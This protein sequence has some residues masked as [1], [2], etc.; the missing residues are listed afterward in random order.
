MNDIKQ[1]NNIF[2]KSQT[3]ITN[4]IKLILIFISLILV[5][6]ISFQIYLYYSQE[7]IKKTLNEEVINIK[8]TNNHWEIFGNKRKFKAR[9]IIVTF[10]F[11]QTKKLVKKYL[12]GSFLK[13]KVKMT[14]NLTV[15]LSQKTKQSVPISSIKLNNSLVSWISNENSKKR[16]TKK[17]CVETKKIN[18]NSKESSIQFAGKLSE[19]GL[20]LGVKNV[21]SDYDDYSVVTNFSN[22]CIL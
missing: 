21:Q 15:L 6:F 4:N 14:P 7:K 2:K 8:F 20:S 9:N 3:F 1:K 18:G 12:K 22:D 10:P 13:L 5:C 16:F 19:I 17:N 11:D